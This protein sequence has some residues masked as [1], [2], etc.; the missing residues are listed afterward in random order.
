L[1]AFG[2]YNIDV[3][4]HRDDGGAPRVFALPGALRLPPGALCRRNGSLRVLAE[5]Y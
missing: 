4:D 2:D 1:D 5:Q 3:T